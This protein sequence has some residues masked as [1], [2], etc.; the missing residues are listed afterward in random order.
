MRK[1]KFLLWEEKYEIKIMYISLTKWK[2]WMSLAEKGSNLTGLKNICYGSA[3][4]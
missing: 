2:E 1:F 3:V 4:L